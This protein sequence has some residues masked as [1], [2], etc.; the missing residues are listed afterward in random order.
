MEDSGSSPSGVTGEPVDITGLS[1]TATYDDGTTGSVVPSSYTPTS[2][3]DTAGTQ[4]VTFSFEGTD[5][6]VDVDYDV[7]ASIVGTITSLTITGTATGPN[8]RG[9]KPNF[10][11]FT[12]TFGLEGGESIVKTGAEINADRTLMDV[13]NYGGAELDAEGNWAQAYATGRL[14]VKPGEGWES[15]GYDVDPSIEY[16]LIEMGQVYTDASSITYESGTWTNSTQYINRPSD[17]TGLTLNVNFPD[18]TSR[19]VS[20]RDLVR[21]EAV[22]TPGSGTN[23]ANG[24][25][26]LHDGTDTDGVNI[27]FNPVDTTSRD[28][29]GNIYRL[30]ANVPDLTVLR[31]NPA[32]VGST[33]EW[34]VNPT[35]T[36]QYTSD[37]IENVVGDD[38]TANN[39]DFF[40]DLSQ[41]APINVSPGDYF[42][43]VITEEDYEGDELLA[44]P[45]QNLA[46]MIVGL[47]LDTQDPYISFS[48]VTPSGQNPI[49]TDLKLNFTIATAGTYTNQ[50]VMFVFAKVP[51]GIADNTNVAT[52]KPT[53][54][55]EI[56]SV[57]LTC[58]STYTPTP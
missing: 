16:Q 19:P 24:W 1:F 45:A 15:L 30:I 13:D 34:T 20:S 5:I 55:E 49:K 46:S 14:N 7:E 44:V 28:P 23:F 10:T 17:I 26:E 41:S 3:G 47:G 6:T 58:D 11:G 36:G 12:F 38:F 56:A 48:E 9:E 40:I 33:L 22:I 2:F 42:W 31:V 21:G 43:Y 37:A 35:I 29:Q 57:L 8:E 18:G 50:E 27:W 39:K 51:A 25:H 52:L 32:N 53:D 4:T 54:L